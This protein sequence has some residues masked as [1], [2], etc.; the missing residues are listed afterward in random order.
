MKHSADIHVVEESELAVK[1]SLRI[2]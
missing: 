2:R 1:V